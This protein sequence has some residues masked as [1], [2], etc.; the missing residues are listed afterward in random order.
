MKKKWY[1]IAIP[2][3]LL[4]IQ[5]IRID[6]KNPPVDL[7][8]DFITI[9]NPP[10]EIAKMIK[11][12]CYDCHSHESVYPWYSNV[13]PVSWY[14]KNHINEARGRVNFSEWANYPADKAAHKLE[15]CSEDV[16][17]GDMPLSSYTL[18]HSNAKLSDVQA[19][20]LSEWFKNESKKPVE[21]K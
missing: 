18:M 1:L 12:S 21:T 6:K 15:A 14:L 5:F 4:I 9:T 17:E 7:S 13:A 19:K 2:A 11:S 10:V 8:K 20:T 3:F 16:E